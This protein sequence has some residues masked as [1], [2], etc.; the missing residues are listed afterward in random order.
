MQILIFFFTVLKNIFMR[1]LSANIM[2]IVSF[3]VNYG[4]IIIFNIICNFEMNEFKE[5]SAQSELKKKLI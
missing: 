1:I 5:L 2:K 4:I 3:I